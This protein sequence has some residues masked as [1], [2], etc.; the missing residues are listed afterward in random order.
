MSEDQP[1][2][3]S[4]PPKKIL[5]LALIGAYVVSAAAALILIQRGRTARE[6][7]ALLTSPQKLFGAKRGD[8]VGWIPLRGAIY[9]Q[10]R[11]RMFGRGLSQW[12]ERLKSMADR[13]DV[14]AIIIEI[15]SPGGS[16]GAVQELYSQVARVRREKKKPVVAF[17]GDVAASGGYYVA[18]ACDKIVAHPGTLTGSVGVIFQTANME[19]LLSK[20]GVKSEPIKSGKFKDIG[21]TM[22]AMTPEERALLQDLIDDAYGQFLSAV[23]QGRKMEGETVR[24]LA[25]G[26]IFTGRQALAN[27]LVDQLGDS[28]DALDLAAKL[29]GISGTPRVVRETDPLESLLVLL[30]S[31]MGGLGFGWAGRWM[32][33]HL[34]APTLATGLEYRWPGF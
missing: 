23:S 19:G 17:L 4:A 28:Q 9:D 6:A 25:D 21:S 8:A 34:G 27:G 13:K 32:E 18:A 7:A 31:H 24:P 2:A 5:V 26:R 16:I 10:D 11:G 29:G 20:I 3:S 12:T 22:R 15:N 30:D 1:L 14:K 33:S